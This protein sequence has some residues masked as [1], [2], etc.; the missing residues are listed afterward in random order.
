M[1]VLF[2][3]PKPSST[4]PEPDSK[5]LP[6]R[7][8]RRALKQ[9]NRKVTRRANVPQAGSIRSHGLHRRYPINLRSMGRYI[10]RNAP[11]LVEQQQQVQLNDLHSRLQL[12][13][14]VST[15]SSAPF[16]DQLTGPAATATIQSSMGQLNL[17]PSS[18]T[19]PARHRICRRKRKGQDQPLRCQRRLPR[20]SASPAATPRSQASQVQRRLSPRLSHW[21]PRPRNHQWTSKQLQAA[22]DGNAS[23]H[24]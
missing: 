22:Q 19:H 16:R 20:R 9:H 21:L 5:E 2:W 6:S 23:E 12:S 18:V 10:R 3:L 17:A 8:H 7:R 15:R 14:S 4:S 1:V 13:F 11:T 24:G